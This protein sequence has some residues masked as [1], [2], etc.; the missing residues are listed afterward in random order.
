MM[1]TRSHSVTTGIVLSLLILTACGGSGGGGGG[2]SNNNEV[3]NPPAQSFGAMKPAQSAEELSHSLREGLSG[4]GSTDQTELAI[5]LE[6]GV[7]ADG[8]G[9]SAFSSTTLQE[10]GVDEADFAKYDGEILYLLQRGEDFAVILATEEELTEESAIIAAPPQNSRIHLLRTDTE[11]PAAEEVAVIEMAGQDQWLHGLY[12]HQ[13]GGD[14][15]LVSIG[16]S[17]AP[18]PMAALVVDSFWQSGKTSISAWNVSNPE[19]PAPGWQMEIDGSLLDSRRIDNRL[20]LLTRYTPFVDGLVHWPQTEEEEDANQQLLDATELEDLL[21]NYRF[22]EGPEAEL[23]AAGDCYLPNPDY[24]SDKRA[25]TGGGLVTVTVI[26]LEAPSQPQSLCL[27]AESNGFYASP[28]SI[29]ITSAHRDNATL[30]HKIALAPEG[31]TYRGTGEV[32]GYIGTANP[33][34]LMSEYDGDLRVVSSLWTS[35]PEPL[36]GPEAQV[37]ENA[38]FGPHRLSILRESEDGTELETLARLPNAEQPA[39]IGKPG[40]Q[41]FA[42][43]FL[44]ERA[45]VVT[46]EIV[47]PLYVLDLSDPL[48]PSISGELELPGFSTVL[49]PLGENLLLGVG[50]EVPLDAGGLVQGVKVGLFDVSDITAPVELGSQVIGLRGSY[51]P[52]QYDHHAL[53]VHAADAN[54]RVALPVIR[55]AQAREGD[56]NVSDPRY[57]YDWSDSGLYQFDI[58]P[59]TG[60]LQLRDTVIVDQRTE[61]QHW[62]SFDLYDSRSFIHDD[63]LFFTQGGRVWARQW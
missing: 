35:R 20:Y 25:I 13:V 32:P 4:I 15:T 10:I 39:P 36:P 56:D 57:W 46:F 8:P 21:P 24:D 54:Y 17:N 62:P 61:K 23:L 42:A 27:H 3:V 29:Y 52:A 45:Y 26:D 50:S 60:G 14:K 22:D 40:E 28:E 43:R 38:D 12:L 59:G 34:F 30:V 1:T 51:S 63:A 9:G 19:S 44:G 37:D 33:S 18:L 5:A 31:P 16:Q 41:V 7:A 58:E 11:I 6:A 2:G 49:Q 47:D 53:T 55:H 48:N